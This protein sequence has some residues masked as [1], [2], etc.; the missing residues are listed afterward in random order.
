ME[1]VKR[2]L[3]WPF[4]TISC[5]AFLGFFA[6]FFFSRTYST[7][8][9]ENSS[10]E[11]I[12]TPP[13]P[14]IGAEVLTNKQKEVHL[15]FG[16][17]IMLARAVEWSIEEHDSSYP[18]EKFAITQP[19]DA[20]I[21]NFE[22]TVRDAYH[23]EKTNVM[24]FDTLP[25]NLPSLA[26]EGFT[27][28]SLAN[29]HADDF[30]DQ[31]TEGTRLAL[32]QQGVIPFGDPFRSED[33]TAHIDAEIPITL[34]GFHAFGEDPEN[35]SQEIQEAK[36][37]GDTVIVFPHWGNEYENAPSLAQEYAAD[38]WI[39]AG[40]D[41]IIGA[42]PHVVQQS[43]VRSGIPVIYS[44][45]NLLFDQDFSYETQHG[46]LADVTI[47]EDAFHVTF[48]PL[49]IANRQ[50]FLDNEE[51]LTR[52]TESWLGQSIAKPWIIPRSP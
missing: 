33:F 29:N 13:E 32:A 43:E 24:A 27:H 22:G 8:F 35:L 46:V 31:V 25:K 50:V 19:Y 16:G 7:S 20:I 49:T 40:A 12:I 48:L 18:W 26:S 23:I 11:K 37:R 3:L 1:N 9:T 10:P 34:I 15:L 17:D 51:L 39:S 4:F 2:W 21:A 36:K 30:G 42:H 45:G 6:T 14:L 52:K 28:L 38:V 47:Y 44:L 5:I 41:L